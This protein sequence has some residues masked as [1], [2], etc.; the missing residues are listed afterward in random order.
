MKL[1]LIFSFF[2]SS[3]VFAQTGYDIQPDRPGLGE[4]SQVLKKGY[5]QIESGGNY[6]WDKMEGMSVDEPPIYQGE[7]SFNSTFLRL[8]ISLAL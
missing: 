5:L 1:L 3:Y 4:S 8:G 6:Q 2:C 7:I